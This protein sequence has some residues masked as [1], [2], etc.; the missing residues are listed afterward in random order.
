[1]TM[2]IDEEW[3]NFISAE[4]EEDEEIVVHNTN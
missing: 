3:E 1:M 2:D 4:Y